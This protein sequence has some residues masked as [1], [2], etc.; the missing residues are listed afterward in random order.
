MGSLGAFRTGQWPRRAGQDYI[1]RHAE[2]RGL[3]PH[4][5]VRRTVEGATPARAWREHLGLTQSDVAARIGISQ[6]AYAQQERGE[7]LRKSTREKIAAAL[8]IQPRQLDF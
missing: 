1:A 6:S 7:R 8:G 2:E 5:V 3:I 4:A